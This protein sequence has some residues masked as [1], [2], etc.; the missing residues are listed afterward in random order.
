MAEPVGLLVEKKGAQ[1]WLTLDRPHRRNALT[2]ELVE[3]VGDALAAANADDDVRVAVVTGSGSAFCAGGDLPSLG[4][5]AARGARAAT[6]MIYSHF[7]R[8][9]GLLGSVRFPVI[10]AVNG[11]AMGAGLDL[12]MACDLRIASESARFAS[13]WINV[14]LVPGMGGAHLLTRAIGASRAS[15]LVLLGRT[16]DAATA[17]DWGLVNT[18]VSPE[19]LLAKAAALASRF[20]KLSVS[21]VASSKASLRRAGL[22]PFDAELAT[23]GAVQGALLVSDEF[24]AAT[25]ALFGAAPEVTQ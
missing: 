21:A 24:K 5:V 12:A 20:E 25:A 14:G 9:V 22:V 11:P 1:V 4:A 13:S 6:D 23:L 18:V 3:A 16:I 15:E 17:L 10:A 19:A 7:H 8:M 2:V